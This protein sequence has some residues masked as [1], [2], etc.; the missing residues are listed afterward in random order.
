MSPEFLGFSREA[1]WG[2]G[3]SISLLP[4]KNFN[5][6]RIS[7]CFTR[8]VFWSLNGAYER[9]SKEDGSRYSFLTD[10][11]SLQIA[12]PIENWPKMLTFQHVLHKKVLSKYLW[13]LRMPLQSL[14]IKF[15]AQ[16]GCESFSWAILRWC[17]ENHLKSFSVYSC[18]SAVEMW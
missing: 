17:Q 11:L 14:T 3:P 12:V 6:S 13:Y 4:T 7:I 1:K 5:C 2:F 15:A 16:I 8:Q 10:V 9:Y 18:K